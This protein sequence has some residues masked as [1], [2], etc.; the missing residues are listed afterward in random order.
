MT[1]ERFLDFLVADFF[2]GL[3][4]GHFPLRCQNCKRHF[5]QTAA[6]HK[7]YCLGIDPRD[8]KRRSCQAVAAQKGREAREQYADHPIKRLCDTRLK[9]IR[10]HVALGKI[11]EGQAKIA[12]RIAQDR[13]DRALEDNYYATKLY[14][15]E[16]TQE[17][18]YE[19]AGILL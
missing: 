15:Q 16:M 6:H 10:T 8:P 2:E 7:K 19:T 18:V 3:H 9:T 14:Q 12:K 4:S 11:T 5:L 17:A 1:F 13:R